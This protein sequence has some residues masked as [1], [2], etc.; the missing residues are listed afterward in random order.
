MSAAAIITGA[1]SGLGRACMDAVMRVYP[2]INEIWLI[3]RR[4]ERLEEIAGRYPS[5]KCRAIGLDLSKDESIQT[6]KKILEES[7]P[8]IKL[9]VSNSGVAYS[10]NFKDTDLSRQMSMVDLNVK[11]AMAVTHL[12]LPYMGRGSVILETCSVSA[13]APTPGQIV[14][15]ATKEYLLFFSKGLREELKPYGINVC[16]LCPGNMD[17]E[18]NAKEIKVKSMRASGKMPFLDIDKVAVKSLLAAENGKAVYTPD[19]AYKGYR[20]LAKLLPHN[21]IMKFSKMDNK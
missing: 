18:M 11:G 21:L 5:G 15:S 16:A 2:H 6:L 12:C 13:F 10:G 20:L 9:L 4:K 3:A 8:D 14:Y 1:S 7:R 19:A 17:T